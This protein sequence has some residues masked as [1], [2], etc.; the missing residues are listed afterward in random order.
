R[1][2]KIDDTL[3]LSFLLYEQ[4]PEK[5][6][7]ELSMLFGIS[8]YSKVMITANSGSAKSMFT[9]LVENRDN[10]MHELQKKGI[11][12]A[13]NYRA[14]HLLDYYRKRFGYKEGDFPNAEYI[15]NHTITLPL[16]PKLTDLEVEHIIGE[17]NEIV[18]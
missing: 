18:R 5:G 3:I 9:I 14:V 4:Q 17:V 2:L 1:R 8:D 11:G 7:K 10:V 6:L 12:V 15:G 16:Y 13:V